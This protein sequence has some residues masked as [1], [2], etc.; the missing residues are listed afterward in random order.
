[1][2]GPAPF[3]ELEGR[4]DRPRP[5]RGLDLDRLRADFPSLTR[6]P[7]GRRQIYLD[8]AA[9]SQTPLA[10]QHAITRYYLEQRA[11]VH[12]GDYE[13]ALEATEAVAGLTVEEALALGESVRR[14]IRGE[15]ASRDLGDL[16]ALE[17]ISR[18]PVR[19]KCAVL[20]WATLEQVLTAPTLA[21]TARI[22]DASKEAP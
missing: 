20:P 21:A 15:R 7:R 8:S 11:N 9:T 16:G 18:F 4:R 22:E 5:A 12:R 14:L 6:E 19:I 17:G 3:L 2:S 13:S 1:M 10:V